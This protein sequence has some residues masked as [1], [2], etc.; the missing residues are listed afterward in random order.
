MS[1]AGK[2][3]CFHDRRSEACRQTES[4]HCQI[5]AAILCPVMQTD[6]LLPSASDFIT[7][8]DESGGGKSGAQ[9]KRSMKEKPR[10]S[11]MKKEEDADTETALPGMLHIPSWFRFILRTDLM[12]PC[13]CLTGTSSSCKITLKH[14]LIP[15]TNLMVPCSMLTKSKSGQ[16]LTVIRQNI[17]LHV[18]NF[19]WL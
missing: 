15:Q 18:T 8:G 12:V 3:A 16:Y 9:R 10:K 19:Q 13:M 11:R 5:R 2:A 17:M 1:L 7:S 6:G 4:T 14:K